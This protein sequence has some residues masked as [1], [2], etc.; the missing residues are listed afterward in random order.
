M[1]IWLAVD[2]VMA[3]IIRLTF[4]P[5]PVCTVTVAEPTQQFINKYGVRTRRL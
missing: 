2:K 1:K 4:L 5:H 3:K